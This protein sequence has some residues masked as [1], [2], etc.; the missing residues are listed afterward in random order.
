MV[1]LRL[2]HLHQPLATQK[3]LAGR[4]LET[5]QVLEP[6]WASP[7]AMLMQLQRHC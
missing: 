6:G 7:W 5:K 1:D 3:E 2:E 4:Q